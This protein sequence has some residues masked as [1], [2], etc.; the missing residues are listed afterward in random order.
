MAGLPRESGGPPA[1]GL[2]GSHLNARAESQLPS[3][4]VLRRWQFAQRASHRAI[5][6]SIVL[7]KPPILFPP[8][9]ARLGEGELDAL[10]KAHGQT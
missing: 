3:R 9:P 7:Q 5:A 8:P 4:A 1:R 10:L 6:S 2:A